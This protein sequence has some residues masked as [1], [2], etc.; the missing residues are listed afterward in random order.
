MLLICVEKTDILNFAISDLSDID[1]YQS[2]DEE[3]PINAEEKTNRKRPVEDNHYAD[4]PDAEV[5]LKRSVHPKRLWS[6]TEINILKQH[7]K[8]YLRGLNVEVNNKD[9]L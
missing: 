5:D 9:L 1:E 8:A 3:A 4:V 7:F 2:D 6:S